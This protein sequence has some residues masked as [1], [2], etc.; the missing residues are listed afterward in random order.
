[1]RRKLGF[2]L[3]ELL[4]VI[5]IIAILAAILFPVFA[6]AREKAR[7]AS[8]QSQLK[9]IGLALVQYLQDNDQNFPEAVYGGGTG[10]DGPTGIKDTKSTAWGGWVSNVLAPYEKSAA[11]YVCPSKKIKRN[12]MDWRMGANNGYASYCYNYR[13]LGGAWDGMVRNDAEVTEPASLAAMWD[14]DNAWADC[15]YMDG[16]CGINV[17]DLQYYRNKDFTKTCWHQGKNNFLFADGH[18]KSLSWEQV[19]WGQISTAA[20]L[21]SDRNTPVLQSPA[22]QG[23]G[24]TDQPAF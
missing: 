7:S 18:V 6:Q 17:R 3:I 16:G 2:T 4:V 14:G 9:Q 24:A 8:C 15:S 1:M 11:I 19:K 23:W 5:A 10:D 21:N 13:S 12:F 20:Q 22:N